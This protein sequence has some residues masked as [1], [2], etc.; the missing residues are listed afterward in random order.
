VL[1]TPDGQETNEWNLHAGQ[2]SEGVPSRVADVQPG[3]ESTHADQDE[4]VQRQQVCDEDVS[5]PCADHV[6]VEERSQATPH[7]AS[8][9]DGLDPEV[10]GEDQEEDGNGLVVV[11][12]G[13][14]TRDV[15]RRNAHEDGGEQTS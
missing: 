11:A 12:A 4:G 15:A 6:S 14:G 13:D 8:N 1:A 2:R 10:E 7:N 3:A 9:L 5:T